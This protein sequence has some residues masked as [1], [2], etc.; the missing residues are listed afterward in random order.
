MK[1]VSKLLV[2]KASA[3][4]GKTFTLAVEYI[5][6][7]I[8][9]PKAYRSIL[10]VTFT[11]KATAEMKERILS[12]LYGIS[13]KDPLS[14]PYFEA[15]RSNS[16]LSEEQIRLNAEKALQYIIHDYGQFRVETI[17]SFFQ[18]IVR[19]LAHELE[20]G[21][22]LN[23]EL[24][25]ATVLSDA[26]DVMIEKLDAQAQL[27]AWLTEF[28]EEQIQSDHKWNIS[29]AVKQ[30]AQHIFNEQYIEKGEE[31]HKKLLVPKLIEN[32]IKQIRSIQHSALE[33]MKAYGT[34]FLA[35][36]A[37]NSLAIEDF[38]YGNSGVAG[39][40]IK[41][42]KGDISDK[43]AGKRV[44][45]AMEKPEKW[46]PK[47]SLRAEEILSL[48]DSQLLP[49]LQLAESER[50]T[51][52]ML[53]NS[54]LLSLKHINKLRLLNNI[55]EE[56][57]HQN[58]EKGRFLLA[59]ANTLL[60][61]LSQ[62]D[63]AFIF[64]KIG[65]NIQHIMID[66][67]QDTSNLQWDC[68]K[69]LLLE[70]LS[71]GA[72]S[73]IVGDVKQSIYRWRNADWNILNNLEGTIGNAFPIEVKQLDTNHRSEANIVHFNNEVFVQ[74]RNI[75]SQ[76]YKESYQTELCNLDKAYED[77]VQQTLKKEELGYVKVDYI[78]SDPNEKDSYNLQML[79]ELVVAVDELQEAGVKTADICILIRKNKS[80]PTIANYF[81]ENTTYHI[82]SDEAFQLSSSSAIQLLITTLSYLNEPSNPLYKAELAKAYQQKSLQQDLSLEEILSNC[83]NYLPEEIVTQPQQLRMMPL[84]E[85][86]EELTRILQIDKMAQQDAY[87][88]TFF[89]AI[90][91]YLQKN[92]SDLT[93]FLHYWEEKLGKKTIPAGK[94]EGIRI[95]SIHKSKG[96]EVHS[97][98]IPYFDW[99]LENETSTLVWCQPEVA[100][101]NELDLLPI[102]YSSN[103]I[104]SIYTPHY[105]KEQLQLWVDNLNLIYV[106]F[107]RAKKN[108]I[109]LGGADKKNAVSNLLEEAIRQLLTTSALPFREIGD[110]GGIEMGA[111]C[112]STQSQVVEEVQNKLLQ[113][114]TPICVG[115]S[116][117]PPSISFRQSNRSAAFIKGEEI[118]EK[119][120]RFIN[121]GQLLHQLFSGIHTTDDIEQSVKE[122][123][124]EGVIDAD[125]AKKLQLF[126][127]KALTNP[128]AK[129]WFT[130][131]LTL[132]NECAI[133]Y[134]E[135]GVVVQ[136]RPDRVVVKDG[137][138]SII[139]FKFGTPK[140]EHKEQVK[141]YINLLQQMGYT[142]VEG[143]LWYVYRQLI[144]PVTY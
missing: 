127:E 90:I 144:L 131:P 93:A 78:L 103:M 53:S 1:N 115:L 28:I 63:P 59:N 61:K 46:V 98:I 95:L 60:S 2:Y 70:G 123:L 34:Q 27:M 24:D 75:L 119:A 106:A 38:A 84:Y 14:A 35:I 13:T 66:E 32:Y 91:D 87:L 10:A 52:F 42:E 118:D 48:V 136:R 69:L 64:E 129:E 140:E 3:G 49:L 26:V 107:T 58:K 124:F 130:A 23:I 25:M 120:N 31:V 76:Q 74:M 86:I 104:H 122:L 143:Y 113:P 126:T 134:K 79:E 45:D 94:I 105:Q 4:S 83:E 121:E 8:D 47:K 17:D 71:Q 20:L 99:N 96:L 133:L 54:C 73:L 65:S 77:V 22:N 135:N 128:Q 6:L 138:V 89:D 39:Y 139:D 15:I 137:K 55:D 30:F 88:F 18:S 82:V 102:D 117:F 41:L 110:L 43:I 114:S 51:L 125:R 50:H 111:I 29:D 109:V 100:P 142:S 108:L 92:T 56:V 7:L 101:F 21:A 72:N 116:S 16:K 33:K 57:N 141:M 11:N 67:F 37:T 97:V 44:L 81:E 112:P 68:F 80:I 12:Q 62:G 40:F 132:F 19:N 9:A 85:L 5:K 36:L